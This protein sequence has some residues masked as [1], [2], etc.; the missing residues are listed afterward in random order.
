MVVIS[1]PV[2]DCKSLRYRIAAIPIPIC[3][4]ASKIF[5]LEEASEQVCAGG[6][7]GVTEN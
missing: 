2:C 1:L 3:D 6:G 5:L 4:L 7:G